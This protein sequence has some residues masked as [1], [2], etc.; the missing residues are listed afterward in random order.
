MAQTLLSFQ[1]QQR[2]P[3][4][5]KTWQRTDFSAHQICILI[6]ELFSQIGSS[7]MR[8]AF[9]HC[10]SSI[11]SFWRHPLLP[12]EGRYLPQST[13]PKQWMKKCGFTP[14]S[15]F[16]AGLECTSTIMIYHKYS[17]RREWFLTTKRWSCL[18]IASVWSHSFNLK[19]QATSNTYL[20][21]VCSCSWTDHRAFFC[22]IKNCWQ[23]STI[24]KD[25]DL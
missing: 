13:T 7:S 14:A 12:R 22:R 24:F 21:K 25:T 16:S 9:P 6:R 3:Y 8:A 5:L 10:W 20:A 15:I 2:E 18:A 17:A 4:K 19:M 1:W 11:Y 23:L